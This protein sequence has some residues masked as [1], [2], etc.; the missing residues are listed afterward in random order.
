[1]MIVLSM[2]EHIF[3]KKHSIS[4]FIP[5][6]LRR[7]HHMPT[8]ETEENVTAYNFY[9]MICRAKQVTLVHCTSS[10][11]SGPSEPSRFITQLEKLYGINADAPHTD[12]QSQALRNGRRVAMRHITVEAKITVPNELVIQV[13]KAHTPLP[14]YVSPGVD[15]DEMH[16]HCL[17]ASSINEYINCPLL[18]YLR[19]VEKLRE[20]DKRSDFMDA[21][22]Y[23]SIIHD[24]LQELY[25]P[26]LEDGKERQGEHIVTIAMMEDFKAHRLRRIV[27]RIINRTFINNPEGSPITGTAL[28]LQESIETYAT[29]AIDFDLQLLQQQGFDHLTV[30]E[31]E[32]KHQLPLRMGKTQFNFTFKADRV[33]LLGDTLRIIDYK[34]GRER[35]QVKTVKDLFEDSSDVKR[36]K[37]ILQLVLYCNAWCQ[38]KGERTIQPLIYRLG[39]V[40]QTGVFVKNQ[41]LFFERDSE[42]NREFSERIESVVSE[43]LNQET[44]FI[45]TSKPD[46]HCKWCAFAGFCN[47]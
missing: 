14:D 6:H 31:C 24:T 27:E 43:L 11:K 20:F 8:A 23:G 33:D 32:R 5:D 25:Y 15:E 9:R 37:G 26:T 30:L 1:N 17:S 21:A 45:Q 41:Q 44:P 39:E 13:P 10:Q 16:A 19:H 38:I 28:M 34:T 42:F 29:R 18:F 4:S 22:T 12:A 40:D 2:N 47:R 36:A 46:T 3:P 35:T 7:A